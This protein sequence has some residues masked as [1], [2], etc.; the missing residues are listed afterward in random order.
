[1]NLHTPLEVPKNVRLSLEPIELEHIR[2]MATEIFNCPFRN[3]QGRTSEQ[4]YINTKSG[5]LLEYGMVRQ[6]ATMNPKSF[7]KTDPDSYNWDVDW[8]HWRIELKNT[9]FNDGT[10]LPEDYEDK[11]WVSMPDY[12]AEK[13]LKNRRLYPKCVDVVVLGRHKEV[14]ENVYDVSYEAMVPFDNIQYKLK[15]GRRS[16]ENNIM[17]NKQT[18]EITGYKWIVY[19]TNEPGYYAS[20]YS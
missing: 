5:V 15:E 13:I 6:G 20:I 2:L 14:S 4:V 7:D 18:N 9:H 1:M 17:R 8:K 3:K 16:Y 12:I 11:K 19:P 10:A